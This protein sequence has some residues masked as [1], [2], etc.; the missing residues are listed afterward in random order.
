MILKSSTYVLYCIKK[1]TNKKNPN[2]LLH[3]NVQLIKESGI[4]VYIF[5]LIKK[6]HKKIL[7]RLPARLL[8]RF[9]SARAS[10]TLLSLA[11][12]NI[13]EKWLAHR[14]LS[15]HPPHSNQPDLSL[16]FPTLVGSQPHCSRF[17]LL[18]AR[19]MAWT[20]PAEEMAYTKAD[21]RLP[22]KT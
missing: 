20:T 6:Y 12:I 3:K 22:T 15:L 19:V 2:K 11:S 10:R 9:I 1:A 14:T 5:N 8:W 16:P 18:Q 7:T 4:V 21:S 13:R 17:P